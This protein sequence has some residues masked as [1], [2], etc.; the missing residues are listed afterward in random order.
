[1]RRRR[2][3]ALRRLRGRH[4]SGPTPS[5]AAGGRPLP[6]AP[7]LRRGWSRIGGSPQV[8][9]RPGRRAVAGR[10][11][12]S[13]GRR[14][15]R[16]GH[17]GPDHAGAPAPARVRPGRAGRP[18]HRGPPPRP[19]P[20]GVA[21]GAG[22]DADRRRCGRAPRR[23]T[24]SRCAPCSCRHGRPC[25]RRRHY[26]RHP[27]RRGAMR[28]RRWGPARR[29]ARRRENPAPRGLTLTHG[30]CAGLWLQVDASRGRNDPRKATQLLSMARFRCKSSSVSHRLAVAGGEANVGSKTRS[31]AHGPYLHRARES[32]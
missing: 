16:F 17:V 26:G 15:C 9:Q 30:P 25:R 24:K 19:V 3:R 8:P 2:P 13:A 31:A 4:A 7:G 32:T 29:G 12:G 1:M 6:G 14:A 22:P 11:Y 18:S 28:T 21:P 20:I 27:Q 5:A 23:D 10:R